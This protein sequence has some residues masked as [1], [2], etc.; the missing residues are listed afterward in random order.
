MRLLAANL[1]WALKDPSGDL[2]GTNYPVA[3]GLIG[4]TF[5]ASILWFLWIAVQGAKLK[6]KLANAV[7]LDMTEPRY[8]SVLAMLAV[9]DD[10]RCRRL[11]IVPNRR[12]RG[13]HQA[14][15]LIVM[16]AGILLA[17]RAFAE[18]YLV[19][20]EFTS[21]V[22][23]AHDRLRLVMESGES[24]GWDWDLASGQNIW[25]GDL[26][27]TFGISADTYLAGEDE[28]FERIHPDD[29]ERVSKASQLPCRGKPHIERNIA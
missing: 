25:F 1:V 27:S 22:G 5:T 11:G 17:V 4:M 24:M 18:N 9:L 13:T 10:S 16:L 14:R 26:K 12:T 19:N 20:R 15:L 28:L 2:T 7:V 21:D 3:R 23:I 6:P 29:R 8:S